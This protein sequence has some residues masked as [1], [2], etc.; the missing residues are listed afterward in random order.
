VV[1]WVLALTATIGRGRAL[2]LLMALESRFHIDVLNEIALL[3]DSDFLLSL[4]ALDANDC[5][6]TRL[7]VYLLF[8]GEGSETI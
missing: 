5:G 4:E 2:R 3:G 1:L 7:T 6:F 8:V